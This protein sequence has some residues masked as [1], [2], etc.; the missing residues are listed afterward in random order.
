MIQRVASL[1]SALLL[2]AAAPYEPPEDPEIVIDTT[3]LTPE[4]AADLIV[5]RLLG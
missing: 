4:E 1:L 3:R 5:E 2:I